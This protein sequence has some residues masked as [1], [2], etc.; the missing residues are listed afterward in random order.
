MQDTSVV[1]L[2]ELVLQSG[3]A[4]TGSDRLLPN[5]GHGVQQDHLPQRYAAGAFSL[6]APWLSVLPS[7]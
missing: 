6:P 5:L 3:A 7:V 4:S 2:F 1:V